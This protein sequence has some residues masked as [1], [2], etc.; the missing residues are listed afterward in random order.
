[1][2]DDLMHDSRRS[3]ALCLIGVAL[4]IFHRLRRFPFLQGPS[5]G[6]AASPARRTTQPIHPATGPLTT[7]G[8]ATG[9]VP[10]V[11]AGPSR[12]LELEFLLEFLL[13]FFQIT[14]PAATKNS[15]CRSS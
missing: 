10:T 1:M 9:K 14:A 3:V 12:P 7:Q 11:R 2:V 4:T 8:K 6:N 13:E 15:S 5:F